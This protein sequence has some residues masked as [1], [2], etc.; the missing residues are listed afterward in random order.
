MREPIKNSSGMV[1]SL[2]LLALVIGGCFFIVL[3]AST[4]TVAE[5]KCM[6]AGYPEIRWSP[7]SV[8]YCVRVEEGRTIM[9]PVDELE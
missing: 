7:G 5:N 4:I 8:T 2:I 6:K 1:I 3:S 9:I